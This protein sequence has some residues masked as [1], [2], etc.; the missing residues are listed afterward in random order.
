VD[1]RIEPGGCALAL[2]VSAFLWVVILAVIALL[3]Y[4]VVPSL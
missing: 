2:V 1:T 4:A 3:V